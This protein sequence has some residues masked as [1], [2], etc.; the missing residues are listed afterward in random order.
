VVERFLFI[1]G[2]LTGSSQVHPRNRFDIS[3]LRGGSWGGSGGEPAQFPANPNAKWHFYEPGIAQNP[4]EIG[5]SL[6]GTEISL[7]AR[8]N[9]LLD[10]KKFPARTRRELSRKLLMLLCPLALTSATK[11]ESVKNSLFISL[12]AGNF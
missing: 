7:I 9:S 2:K 1:G 5:S 10:R 11:R 4:L 8:F 12:Q 3:G 6:M